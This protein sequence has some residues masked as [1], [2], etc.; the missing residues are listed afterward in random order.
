MV[1][2]RGVIPHLGA[3]WGSVRFRGAPQGSASAHFGHPPP[4]PLHPAHQPIRGVSKP[5]KRCVMGKGGFGKTG[6]AKLTTRK[7]GGFDGVMPPFGGS[8]GFR[9]VPWGSAK[10]R[11]GP[12][13]APLIRP[14]DPFIPRRAIIAP[15]VNFRLY[16]P[17]VKSESP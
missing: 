14:R 12:M 4:L 11:G 5:P 15:Q 17:D 9:Q 6:E 7:N 1:D 10:F 2:S 8:V 13:C 3:P 16:G